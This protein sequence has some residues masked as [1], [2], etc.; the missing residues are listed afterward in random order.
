MD[1]GRDCNKKQLPFHTEQLR[2]V[3]SRFRLLRARERLVDHGQPLWDL[4]R[5]A[6]TRSQ[7]GKKQ[8]QVVMK[9]GLGQFLEGRLEQLRARAMLPSIDEQYAF[10]ALRPDGPDLQCVPRG[11]LVRQSHV[12]VDA[13]E[14][15]DIQRDRTR[16]DEEHEEMRERVILRADIIDE[17][18][19]ESLCLIAISL[20]PE[21]ARV[22]AIE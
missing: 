18:L 22:V 10:E 17:T 8:T 3:P 19:G 4:S 12:V 16:R 11:E 6:E 5:T 20:Q 9:G 1:A 7:L 14:I 15:T 13:R 2:N 21:N